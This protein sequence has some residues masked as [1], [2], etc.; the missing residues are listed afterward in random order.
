MLEKGASEFAW[1][2]QF[3]E[4]MLHRT[5]YEAARVGLRRVAEIL[6]TLEDARSRGAS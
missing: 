2:D 3:V 6:R 1:D 5:Q 4:V